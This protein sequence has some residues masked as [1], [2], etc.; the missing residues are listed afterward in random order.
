MTNEP[1][2]PGASGPPPAL[3]ELIGKVQRTGMLLGINVVVIV[4][5]MVL[6]PTFF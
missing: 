5:L 4:L 1:P 2:P 6:K 3:I